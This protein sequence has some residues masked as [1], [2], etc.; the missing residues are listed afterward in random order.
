[1]RVYLV[2][3]PVVGTVAVL[4][5]SEW[6]HWRASGRWLGSGE[7]A[8][9]REV[10]V[11]LGFRNR[12]PRAN[13]VNRVRV[14][15]GLRSMDPSASESALVLCG[16]TIGSSVSEAELMARFARERLGY[17][18]IMHLDCTSTTTWENIQNAVP[19]LEKFDTIKIASSSLHAEK[20]RA[21][22]W[23]QRP[24]LAARLARADD[25]RF[26]EMLFLKPLAAYIA[27]THAGA[28]RA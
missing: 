26:G 12:G 25:Y 22:L 1:M 15:T 4:L 24:D 6:V 5:W 16:G 20:G 8:P 13:L 9:G 14:R 11:V 7:S 23:K 10:V 21:Y 17:L 19:L 3:V 28:R 27:L 18:G 2:V